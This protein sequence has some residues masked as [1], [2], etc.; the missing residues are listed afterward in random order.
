MFFK[1]EKVNTIIISIIWGLGVAT[2]FRKICTN[3]KCIV[4]KAP[5]MKNYVQKN[6]DDCYEFAKQYVECEK[7]K[8]V[9]YE[10]DVVDLFTNLNSN[11]DLIE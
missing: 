7:F 9:N 5:K 11:G 4:V 1:D 2:I 8:N 6:D 3:D 10:G